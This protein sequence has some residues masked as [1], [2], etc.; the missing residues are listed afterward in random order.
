[1]RNLWRN[2]IFF[3]ALLLAVAFGADRVLNDAR[4]GQ[5][6]PEQSQSQNLVW[7]PGRDGPARNA[8]EHWEKHARDFPEF[9]SVLEYERAAL[10]FVTSPPPGTLTKTDDRGDTL[11]YDPATNTFAVRDAQGEPRTFFRPDH[12]RAYWDRQ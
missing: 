2:G 4:L 1:M 6:P 3:A 10:A 12:G 5:L 7:S 9:H 11:F 8:E